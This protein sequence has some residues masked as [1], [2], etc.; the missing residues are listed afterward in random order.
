MEHASS[1]FLLHVNY[2]LRSSKNRLGSVAPLGLPTSDGFRISVRQFF[3]AQGF[4]SRG[5][6]PRASCEVFLEFVQ[7]SNEEG[8]TFLISLKCSHVHLKDF[9]AAPV[10]F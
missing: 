10:L 7:S 6:I 8:C 9:S 4:D 1:N 3:V 2:F 5:I